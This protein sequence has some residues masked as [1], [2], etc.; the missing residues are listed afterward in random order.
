M[1][2][3]NKFNNIMTVFL[4]KI[5]LVR[6]LFLHGQ[7]KKRGKQ[8]WVL[9]RRSALLWSATLSTSEKRIR[10]CYFNNV[11][12]PSKSKRVNWDSKE[13]KWLIPFYLIQIYVFMVAPRKQPIWMI[14]VWDTS[15]LIAK[16][17]HIRATNHLWFP[18]A[19]NLIYRKDDFGNNPIFTF[20]CICYG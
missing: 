2:I 10:K 3:W 14:G 19:Y 1:T 9:C 17:K 6:Y 4:S 15:S 16:A 7:S 8:W 13:V 12:Y 18:I 5:G 11:G 20:L